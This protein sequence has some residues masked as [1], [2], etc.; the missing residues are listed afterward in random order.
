MSFTSAVTLEGSG[1]PGLQAALIGRTV[2]AIAGVG[3]AQG[4]A[5]I[6]LSV[7]TVVGTVTTG[8]TAFTLPASTPIG[9]AVEFVNA[10]STATTALL[11]PDSGSALNAAG[12]NNSVSVAQ[13]KSMICVRTSATQWWS[14]PVVPS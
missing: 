10:S 12:A 7:T 1:M 9:D 2:S 8:A 3:T 6:P 11:F 14:I 5:V 13:S 4:G